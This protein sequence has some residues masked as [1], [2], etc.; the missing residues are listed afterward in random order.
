MLAVSLV[1]ERRGS[2]QEGKVTEILLLKELQV[3]GEG[4]KKSRKAFGPLDNV[5]IR[6]QIDGYSFPNRT[7]DLKGRKIKK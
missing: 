5:C 1:N 6:L 7:R 4:L 3:K 2:N